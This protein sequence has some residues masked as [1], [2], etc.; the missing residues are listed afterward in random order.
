MRNANTETSWTPRVHLCAFLSLV[1][2]VGFML[3][4]ISIH[5]PYMDA[6]QLSQMI[7]ALVLTFVCTFIGVYGVLVRNSICIKGR[8]ST[9]D[10]T[11]TKYLHT[12]GELN[13]E[14]EVFTHT[15][16]VLY[17]YALVPD[18]DPMVQIPYQGNDTIEE[19]SRQSS[20]VTKIRFAIIYIREIPH[21]TPYTTPYTV[22][23]RSRKKEQLPKDHLTNEPPMSRI[24]SIIDQS[25]LPS[26]DRYTNSK[27]AHILNLQPRFKKLSSTIY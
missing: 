15:A 9:T 23:V 22:Q 12:R 18:P 3:S 17:V 6:C 26:I 7:Q 10:L 5:T 11:C 24:R 2:Q 8:V 25:D 1:R 14:D 19:N 20:P 16:A 21:Q 4:P 13:S 27:S